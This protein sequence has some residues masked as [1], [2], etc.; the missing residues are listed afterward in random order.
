MKVGVLNLQTILQ[1]MLKGIIQADLKCHYSVT[2]IQ[3]SK[4][5]GKVNYIDKYKGEY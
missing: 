2:Q 4:N 1:E 3:R 5:T